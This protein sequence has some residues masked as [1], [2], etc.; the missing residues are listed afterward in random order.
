MI[1]HASEILYIYIYIN[2]VFLGFY[3][4]FFFL[5]KNRKAKIWYQLTIIIQHL[6]VHFVCACVS[7]YLYIYIYR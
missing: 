6:K 3:R 2:N 7:L 5:E 4:F 1:S